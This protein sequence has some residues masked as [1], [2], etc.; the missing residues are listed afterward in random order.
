[1]GEARR[2]HHYVR[3]APGK[4]RRHE[5]PGVVGSRPKILIDG[6]DD[7][8]VIH[9]NVRRAGGDLCIVA[10]TASS[11]WTDWKIL[12]VEKGPFSSEML[13]DTARW[14]GEGVLSIL[15][16]EE[17]E[18]ERRPSPLRVLDFRP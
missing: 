16:Q 9:G 14:K 2:Y 3:E 17:P 11:G 5:L 10:A 8:F 4:W 13:A 6:K 1:M 7:A 18:G 12:H 15:V